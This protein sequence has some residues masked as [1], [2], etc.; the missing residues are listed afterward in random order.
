[1]AGDVTETR[2]VDGTDLFDQDSCSITVDFDLGSKGC[3]SS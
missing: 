1:M 2:G 3:R